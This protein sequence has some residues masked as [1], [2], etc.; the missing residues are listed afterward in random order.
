MCFDLLKIKL[1]V[2]SRVGS[3]WLME[4]KQTYVCSVLSL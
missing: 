1:T 3:L 2:S 4:V